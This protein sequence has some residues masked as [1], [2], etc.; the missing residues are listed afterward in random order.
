MCYRH[1]PLFS[2]GEFHFT[3]S[4]VLPAE[5]FSYDSV[6]CCWRSENICESKQL[7]LMNEAKIL[8]PD[9]VRMIWRAEKRMQCMCTVG[10]CKTASRN[11]VASGGKA[12]EH[13]DTPSDSLYWLPVCHSLSPS[14]SLSPSLL[15]PFVL[16]STTWCFSSTC[17]DFT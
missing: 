12:K 2:G 1:F 3:S 13:H 6:T 10:H 17:A 11:N 14:A 15:Y 8:H 4:E 5:V 9:L 16:Y 7:N